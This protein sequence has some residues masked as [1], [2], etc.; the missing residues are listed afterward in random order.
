MTNCCSLFSH[1]CLRYKVNRS[2]LYCRYNGTLHKSTASS[3]QHC[4]SPRPASYPVNALH[5]AGWDSQLSA[6][7]VVKYLDG[8]SV[9][10]L[11]YSVQVVDLLRLLAAA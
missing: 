11:Q 9:V 5:V 4:E 3:L 8:S 1:K 6:A 2:H 7:R 10:N